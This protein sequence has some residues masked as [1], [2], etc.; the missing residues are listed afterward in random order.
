MIVGLA[1]GK[2]ALGLYDRSYNLVVRPVNQ[3]LSPVNRIAVPLLSRLLEEPEKYRAVYLQMVR[4]ATILLLPAMLVGI[5]NATLLVRVLLGPHWPDAAPIFSWL[6]VGGIASGIYTSGYWLLISQNRTRELRHLT[7]VAAFINLTSFLVG[8][9]F[10]GVVG[11]AIGASLSYALLTTPLLLLGATR[12][13]PVQPKDLL[14]VATPFV[15]AGIVT[16]A[17]LVFS[18]RRIPLQGLERLGAIT[19]VSYALVTAL[20]LVSAENRRLFA[21]TRELI[22]DLR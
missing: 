13:G 17:V 11:V 10:W 3:L 1:K 16:Y 7:L 5:S 20:C 22:R 2:V 19:L 15:F 9:I 14:F 6:C 12:R 21:R 18:L 8:A 4:V